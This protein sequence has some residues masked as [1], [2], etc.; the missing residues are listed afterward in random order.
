M[1]IFFSILFPVLT[2]IVNIFDKL[3]VDRY[4]G[5]YFYAFWIGIFELALGLVGLGIA[6]SLQSAEGGTILG[7]MLVGAL[8]AGSLALFLAAV[9]LGQVA[10]VVPIWFLY[11]LMVAPMAVVFLDE[12]MSAVIVGAIILAVIGAILVSWQKAEDG[13]L[14]GNPAVPPLTLLAA[15]LLAVSFVLAKWALEDGEFW[16]FFGAYRIGFA[17]VMLAVGMIPK[18]RVSAFGMVRNRGFISLM[19]VI[20]ALVALAVLARFAAVSLG[21]VSLVAAVSAVQPSLVFLYSLALV[22][23]GLRRLDNQ[24]Y[25]TSADD[26]NCGDNRRRGNYRATVRDRGEGYHPRGL[27]DTPPPQ[28]S[29]QGGRR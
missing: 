3:I 24:G 23:F 27:V 19:V 20:E 18:T 25:P 9:K 1:W 6:L 11:P 17:P 14:F 21:E 5:I 28:S 15:G 26:R 8:A 16:Q 12:S 29:P 4:H 2:G 7:A 22:A 13:R 10:R